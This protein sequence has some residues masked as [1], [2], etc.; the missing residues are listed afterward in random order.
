[1]VIYRY[2][3]DLRDDTFEIGK[4]YFPEKIRHIFYF[5]IINNYYF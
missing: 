1:M 4:T 5:I 3:N 2:D